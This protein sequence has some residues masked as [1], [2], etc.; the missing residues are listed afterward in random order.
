MTTHILVAVAWTY[1]NGRLHLGHAAGSLIPADI[2]ARY[3]R[4]Q[5]NQVLMVSGSDT[6]GTPITVAADQE[7]ISPR[8]LFERYHQGFLE[9]QLALGISFDL[10]THT[11]TEN[12]HRVSQ[13][14]FRKLYDKGY[15]VPR[16]QKMLYSETEQRF[17][18]DRYVEGT[19]PNCGFAEARGDQC[20]QCGHL[21][22]SVELIAPRSKID[23]SQPVVRKTT[24]LFFDLPAFSERLLAHLDAHEHHWRSNPLNFTRGFIENGLQERPFTRDLNWGIDVPVPGWEDKKL[25][26]WAENIVGYLSATIEWA[27]NMGQ[28]EAWKAWWYNPDAR[29]YYFLGKDNI[30]FHTIFWPA[31]LLGV[32]R[33]YEDDESKRLNLPYDVPANQ[34][35][36][37]EKGKIST[38]RNWAVWLT[39]MLAAYDPD[40][41]RFYL[42]A[43]LPE[44]T[45][46]DFTWADFVQRNNSELV[47][48]W[49]NLVN[50]VLKFAYKHWDGC[51]PTPGPLRPIDKELLAS[52]DGAF[53]QVGNLLDAVKLRQALNEALATARAVNAYLENAPWFGAVKTDKQAAAT[54]VFTALRAI[55]SI[56]VLL[57]PFLPFSSEQLHHQL[58]YTQPLLGEQCLTTFHEAAR[59]HNALVYDGTGAVGRWEPSRLQSGQGLKRPFPLFKKLDKSIIE[60]E[61]NKLFQT[62]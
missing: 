44:T 54:T 47:A 21:H 43:V 17:L 32:E 49:G 59:S 14:V 18:A 28:P 38:S 12:H 35:L 58:G 37:L 46:S 34:F 13:D 8:A 33:L 10:F 16:T 22:N 40:S 31:E 57:A 26:I 24:H 50:R 61:H 42:T 6:H 27:K 36:T 52:V 20:D 11:D 51:V 23:G 5:G 25:Y 30:P 56:K 7:G 9:S 19:C 39:D 45:D 60:R 1:A 55:D 15:I 4:L 53:E 29:S 48:T 62:T 3:H 2:F 41:I